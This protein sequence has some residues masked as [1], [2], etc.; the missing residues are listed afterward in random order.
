[1]ALF[2]VQGC[3]GVTVEP[4]MMVFKAVKPSVRQAGPGW[5]MMA[6]SIS[7]TWPCIMAG[8]VSKQVKPFC[9]FFG[10]ANNSHRVTCLVLEEF[11]WV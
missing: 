5:R 7:W 8:I 10:K 4:R 9:G 6:G 2:K 3:L 1:M 11:P